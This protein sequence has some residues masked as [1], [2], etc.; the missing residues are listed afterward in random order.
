MVEKSIAKLLIAGGGSNSVL[1]VQPAQELIS[2]LLSPRITWGIS[3]IKHVITL[4]IYVIERCYIKNHRR[5][6]IPE[7]GPELV[8][9]LALMYHVIP[10]FHITTYDVFM[11]PRAFV[12]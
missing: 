12:R 8:P 6:S 1:A 7:V 10:R 3:Q 9:P 11:Y 2:I 5:Q 4:Y